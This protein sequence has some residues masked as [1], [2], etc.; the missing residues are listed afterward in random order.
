M[1]VELEMAKEIEKQKNDSIEKNKHCKKQKM[2]QNFCLC[3]RV[4]RILQFFYMVDTL[5]SVN[6]HDHFYID[7]LFMDKVY[8]TYQ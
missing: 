4:T 6:L 7:A 8:K 1:T 3:F 2:Y 5:V